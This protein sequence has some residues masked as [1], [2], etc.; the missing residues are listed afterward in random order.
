MYIKWKEMV[1]NFEQCDGKL[2]EGQREKEML[3]L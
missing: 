3:K 1:Q 2:E